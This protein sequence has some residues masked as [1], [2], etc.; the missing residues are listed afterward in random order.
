L[1]SSQPICAKKKNVS[2]SGRDCL[3]LSADIIVRVHV[4]RAS[5]LG[6]TLLWNAMDSLR[7]T[8]FQ[9]LIRLQSGAL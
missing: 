1:K 3:S 5:V 7:A 4:R 9:M 6:L 8:S 2:L